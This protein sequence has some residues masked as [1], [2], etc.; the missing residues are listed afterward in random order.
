LYRSDT[1]IDAQAKVIKIKKICD[2]LIISIEI[3]MV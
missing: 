3:I 1:F 2:W